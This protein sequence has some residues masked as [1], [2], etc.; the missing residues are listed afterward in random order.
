[1]GIKTIVSVLIGASFLCGLASAQAADSKILQDVAKT[2][3]DSNKMVLA[4]N[5]AWYTKGL[6]A[7]DAMSNEKGAFSHIFVRC[8]DSKTLKFLDIDGD[9]V[10][11]DE[12][13]GTDLMTLRMVDTSGKLKLVK[14]TVEYENGSAK[15]SKEITLVDDTK[16]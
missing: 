6:T 11:G 5:S 1:M 13:K 9:Q 10:S 2:I 4:D 15:I 14:R 8:A 7:E 16:I 3:C 12:F